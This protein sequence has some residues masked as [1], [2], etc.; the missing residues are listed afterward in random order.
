MS[1]PELRC[2]DGAAE[3]G[4]AMAGSAP[5]SAGWLALEQG[6]PWGAKAFTAS[7]LPA[8]VGRALEGRAGDHGVRPVLIRRPGRHPDR[9]VADAGPRRVLV[10][11]ALPGASWLLTGL[12]RDPAD[13][14]DLD[15]AAVAA[16]DRDA[17]VGSL[18]GLVPE[19]RP[20]LLVCTNGT[21]DL[22]CATLGRPVAQAA[23]A[24][25]PEQVWEVTHTS[26]HR[27]APTAV[28]LPAGTLHG[29]LDVAAA[30]E[31]LGAADRGETVLRGHRGRS[32]WPA[33]G[34]VAELAVREATGVLGLDDL[35]V[36]TEA[37][38]EHAWTCL[39][40]HRDGRVWRVAVTSRATR[41]TRKESCRKAAVPLRR[42]RAELPADHDVR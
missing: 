11:H 19:V 15:W 27:F 28:L 7:H 32:C 30:V 5:L 21:R 6:G 23:A 16:G 3:A 13:L 40:T 31:V 18:P 41:S 4:E 24:L 2:S 36:A 39:V 17:V 22:C 10:A 37:V 29:R 35:R 12:L 1:V 42:W 26:G 34:Q 33:A 8:A 38:G 20:Q 14:L 25:A 9:A